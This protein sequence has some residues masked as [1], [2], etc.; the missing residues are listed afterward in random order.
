MN[1]GALSPAPRRRVTSQ[2]PAATLLAR[3]KLLWKV[4][5]DTT[6]IALICRVP[7]SEVYNALSA[8]REARRQEPP[9]KPKFPKPLIRFV[10]DDRKQTRR[11]A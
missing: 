8:D 11:S 10:G 7:E 6:Q 4:G 5:H 1:T 2:A 9:A 3:Y